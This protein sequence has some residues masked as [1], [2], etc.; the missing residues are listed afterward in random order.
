MTTEATGTR[1]AT[2]ASS[3]TRASSG[4]AIARSLEAILMVADEPQSLV[5]LATAVGA[6]TAA[7]RQAVE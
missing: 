3:T 1:E 7:V 4:Q 2:R 6:P 5:S